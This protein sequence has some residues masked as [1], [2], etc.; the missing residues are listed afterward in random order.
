LIEKIFSLTNIDLSLA[1]KIK[2]VVADD[3]VLL[4]DGLISYIEKKSDNIQI[5]GQASDWKEL[6]SLLRSNIPCDLALLDIK[7]PGGD[8]LSV[9]EDIKVEYP[10]IR[11]LMMSS[12]SEE[13]YA[14]RFI[15]AGASG[16]ISK[17]DSMRNVIQSIHDVVR[18]NIVLSEELKQKLT[19]DRINKVSSYS[20]IEALS[21]REFQVMV[22]LGGGQSI[23]DV[24]E[25]LHL[26]PRTVHTHRNNIL[27]KMSWRN[28]AELMFYVIKKGLV[29]K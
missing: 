16:F 17:V 4:R 14:L 8:G 29:D 10:D 24:A 23:S 28:N 1:N 22:Q 3:H 25:L 11:V 2:V 26:S 12:F 20:D 6:M 15:N 13:E 18:G 5:V 9:V 19:L 27:R 7:M 21:N